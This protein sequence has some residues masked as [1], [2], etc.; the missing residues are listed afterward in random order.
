[1]VVRQMS[2]TDP[3]DVTLTR[4]IVADQQQV[5]DYARRVDSGQA[6]IALDAIPVVNTF[7]P[8]ATG[9]VRSLVIVKGVNPETGEKIS[10]PIEMYSDM[11][12]EAQQLRERAVQDV[13][14]RNYQDT[15]G[16]AIHPDLPPRVIST[17]I[18]SVTRR[19]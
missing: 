16:T 11:P 5:I 3:Q 9:R 4:G 12:I 6:R 1:M 10:Y 18:V 15:I 14:S 13:L 19:D 17:V 8:Q 7:P 2:M